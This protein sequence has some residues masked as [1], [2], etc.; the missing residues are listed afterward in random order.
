MHMKIKIAESD[1]EKRELDWLLW[2]VLWRPL[3]LPRGVRRSFGLRRPEMEL[4]ALD[5]RRVIGGLVAYQL[6]EHEFEIRHLAVHADYQGRSVGR[7][8]VEELLKVISRDSVV[9]VQTYARNT[10]VGFFS[11]L[12]F[13]PEGGFVERED[14]ARHGIKFQKMW[15]AVSPAD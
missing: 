13:I 15:L 7:L 5:Q 1:R 6:A 9:W 2:E 11:R 14:F 4:V 8:L 12:G 10:S 3:D